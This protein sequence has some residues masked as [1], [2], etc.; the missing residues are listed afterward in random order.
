M[1]LG[2]EVQE[3]GDICIYIYIYIYIYIVNSLHCTAEG[4][5]LFKAILLQ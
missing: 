2:G 4:T 5:T 3:V 1:R